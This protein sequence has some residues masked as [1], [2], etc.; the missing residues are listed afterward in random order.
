MTE[1]T[2]KPKLGTRTPLGLKRTVETGKVKQSFSHGRSNTVVVE[3]KKRRILGRAGSGARTTGSG[4]AA[5]AGAQASPAYGR[6]PRL[7][8]RAP[9]AV[10]AP[11]RGRSS[12]RARGSA[13]ARGQAGEG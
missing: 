2:D 7:P 8:P 4:A 3:V 11:G 1:T 6:R 9:G 12:L 5:R 10:A 13:S